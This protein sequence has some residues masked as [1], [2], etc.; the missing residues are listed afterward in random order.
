MTIHVEL[1]SSE[2]CQLTLGRIQIRLLQ[3]SREVLMLG[4]VRERLGS[5]N[6]SPR[7]V[8]YNLC[9]SNELEEF[10]VTELLWLNTVQ[11]S[12]DSAMEVGDKVMRQEVEG[13][14]ISF[15]D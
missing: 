3:D 11:G 5:R 9:N 4:W 8:V 10:Q 13:F 6:Q 7:F 2:G 12:E 14:A 1:H 15:L